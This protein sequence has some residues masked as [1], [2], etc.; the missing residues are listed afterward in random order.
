MMQDIAVEQHPTWNGLAV[1]H[2]YGDYPVSFQAIN[3]RK[4]YRTTAHHALHC[5]C[6]VSEST[7]IFSFCYHTHVSSQQS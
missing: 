6:L 3:W 5:L 1:N 7:F 2:P 4:T